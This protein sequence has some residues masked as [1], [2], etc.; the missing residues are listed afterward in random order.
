MLVLSCGRSKNHA[1]VHDFSPAKKRKKFC[2]LSAVAKGLSEKHP[3]PLDR[4]PGGRSVSLLV[5][6]GG[7][8]VV[9]LAAFLCARTSLESAVNIGD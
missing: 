8:I 2:E 7:C 5:S 3:H 6:L 4:D 9:R 1:V